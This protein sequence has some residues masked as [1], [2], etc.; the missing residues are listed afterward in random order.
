MGGLTAGARDIIS[1]N[2]NDGVEISGSGTSGNAVEGNYIGTEVSGTTS[3]DYLTGPLSNYSDGVEIDGRASGNTVGGLTAAARNIIAGN[4]NAGVE[5]SG[6]GTS[7]NVVQGDYIGTDVAGTVAMGNYEGV[8]I[9]SGASGNT[10]GGVTGTSYPF[11]GG[12]NLISGNVTGISDS[13]GGDNLFEGNLIGTNASGT[14][15]L[16]NY[17]DGIDVSTSGDTIGG[18]V[19]GAGN[20]IAFNY[21]DAVEVVTGI[22][23]AILENVVYGNGSGIVLTSDGN[24][25]QIAP[26]ITAVT[27]EPAVAPSA[28][29]TISVDPTAA[30]FTPGSTYSLDFF[31]D[32]S[33]DP[34]GGVQ[35]HY[36]LGTETFTGGT[37]GNVTFTSSLTPLFESQTVTATATLLVGSTYT[38]TSGFAAAAT[39]TEL[40]DFVVTT[41]AATGAGSLEQAILD[42]NAA[43]SDPKAYVILFAI[44]TG[45]APYTINPLAA[46]LTPITHAVV[47]DATSQPGYDGALIVV[48]DG[49]GVTT[50][51]LVLDTGSDGSAIR[52]F[53]IINF[54]AAGTAG[55][56]IESGDNVVQANYVGV[57]T[58]GMSVGQ[59]TEGVLVQGANNTIGGTTAGGGNLISGNTGD[60]VEISGSVRRAP[61]SKATGSAPTLQALLRLPTHSAS[62]SIRAR[63]A[64][65]SA[66]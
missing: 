16:A 45:S 33:N 28:E 15:A 50:S 23:N 52:G 46:G 37:T 42:A 6:A 58:D 35:A 59:N 5:I 41:T 2:Q 32:S 36:Y 22:G 40:S 53:D 65:R 51:G 7:G 14:G 19:A 18:T 13:G 9:D 48:L 10:I 49:I 12:S 17:G 64:T 54:T 26:V 30:G 31:A 3:Y 44:A 66:V 25:D 62:R 43:T 56:E 39:V 38:N 63:R 55:I 24:D 8:E 11:T 61:W 60:G 47:I 1:G 57:Q 34:A 21:D 4:Y 27:T 29:I 20:T